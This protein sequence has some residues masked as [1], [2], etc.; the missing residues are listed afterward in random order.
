M[1]ESDPKPDPKPERRKKLSQRR[2]HRA[3]VTK[4]TKEVSNCCAKVD[5]NEIDRARLAGYQASLQ[6]KLDTLALLDDEIIELISDDDELEKDIVRSSEIQCEIQGSLKHIELKLQP[7]VPKPESAGE[8]VTDNSSFAKHPKLNIQS[9]NGNPLEFQSF[10]DCFSAS[11]DKTSLKKVIK[12]TYLKSYLTGPARAAID[13][14]SLVEANYDEAVQILHD[15]FGNKQLLISTNI[16]KLINLPVVN[17]ND[18]VAKLREM[19]NKIEFCVRNLKTLE[20]S[21]DQYASVLVSLVMS[22]IPEDIRLVI[23]RVMP[24]NE[25]WDTDEFLEVFR[26]EVESREMCERLYKNSRKDSGQRKPFNGNGERG[27]QNSEFSASAL[28]GGATT[29]SCVYCGGNHTAVACTVITEVTA[30][31]TILRKKARCFARLKSGHKVRN[32]RCNVK[33]SKGKKRHHDSICTCTN[34]DA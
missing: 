5:P 9:F 23:T 6:A 31:T 21:K 27:E 32:C 10:W 34:E 17:G 24:L 13:G 14:I 25:E 15:R 22:K 4:I 7:A 26:K 12:F 33:C 3:Y 8:A 1:S 20:V 18:G 30:R 28:V 16:G 19:Y 11:V 2:G 29:M